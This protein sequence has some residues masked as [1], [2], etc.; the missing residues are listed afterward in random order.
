LFES[1]DLE[2]YRCFRTDLISWE[3]QGKLGG[4]VFENANIENSF[5]TS[6]LF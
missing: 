3:I 1:G 2:N 5:E 4:F 6:K